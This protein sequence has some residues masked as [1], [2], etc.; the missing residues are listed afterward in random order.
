MASATETTLKQDAVP[1]KKGLFARMRLGR[2]NDVVD[3]N[4][5]Q[6]PS[7]KPEASSE[8]RRAPSDSLAADKIS[9]LNVDEKDNS[10]MKAVRFPVKDAMKGKV[11]IRTRKELLKPPSAREAAYGGPP[12]YDWIDIVSG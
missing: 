12:R 8:R 2:R 10:Q 6:T 7:P 4:R 11:G 5:D 3:D 1:R 9:Y